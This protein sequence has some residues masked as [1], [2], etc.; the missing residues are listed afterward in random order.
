M[1]DNKR[2]NIMQNKSSKSLKSFFIGYKFKALPTYFYTENTVRNIPKPLE[3]ADAFFKV[4][5]GRPLF[6]PQ[7]YI[8]SRWDTLYKKNKKTKN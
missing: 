8:I 5:F 4:K 3:C 7:N 1:D 2:Y 6:G